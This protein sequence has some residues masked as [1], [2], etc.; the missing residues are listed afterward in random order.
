MDLNVK[1]IW[2]GVATKPPDRVNAARRLLPI[3]HF[4]DTPR[5]RIGI[6]HLRRYSRKFNE[7]LGTYI[8]PLH[9]EH[10]HA[11]DAFGEYAINCPIV[12]AKAKPE[13][14]EGRTIREM[15]LNEAWDL[16]PKKGSIRI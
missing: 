4:N 13:A 10:S 2:V 16:L 15:T 5:V 7:Q 3:V 1:P 8:G 9:D 6:S 11:A 14:P 12:P